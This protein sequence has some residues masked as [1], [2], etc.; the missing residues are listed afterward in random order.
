MLQKN[1]FGFSLKVG[2]LKRHSTEGIAKTTL[3]NFG[4]VSFGLAATVNQSNGCVQREGLAMCG[5]P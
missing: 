3:P 4:A 2:I 5:I 1:A